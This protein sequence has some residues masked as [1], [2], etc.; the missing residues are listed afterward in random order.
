MSKKC[1]NKQLLLVLKDNKTGEISISFA[2]NLT[3]EDI[4]DF[5]GI[6]TRICKHISQEDWRINNDY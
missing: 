6:M 1:K 3:K 2:E 4:S 5:N